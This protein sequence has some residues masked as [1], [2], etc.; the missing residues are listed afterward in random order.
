MAP[1]RK[2][3]SRER[4]AT[5]RLPVRRPQLMGRARLTSMGI[6]HHHTYA[7]PC[8]VPANLGPVSHCRKSQQSVGG[9]PVCES[10]PMGPTRL[11]RLRLQYILR[12]GTPP[13]CWGVKKAASADL[14]TSGR[15]G[16][17]FARLRVGSCPLRSPQATF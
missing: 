17:I 11:G 8:E 3:K 16:N 6:C 14:G 7:L 13:W 9:A 1:G 5:G 10:P 2:N 4:Q 15:A 12:A